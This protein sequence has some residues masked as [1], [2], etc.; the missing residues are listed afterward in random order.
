MTEILKMTSFYLKLSYDKGHNC[1]K[2]ILIPGPIL[3]VAP[4]NSFNESEFEKKYI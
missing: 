4:F 1:V 3:W 2:N